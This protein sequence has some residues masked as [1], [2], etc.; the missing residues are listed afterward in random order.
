M[1][2]S[3][4]TQA[5]RELA[6]NVDLVPRVGNVTLCIE[7]DRE[8]FG[9]GDGVIVNA[10]P[11]QTVAP[12]H[13]RPHERPPTRSSRPVVCCYTAEPPADS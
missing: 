11:V 9:L 8:T 1:V 10:G 7:T 6:G 4:V 2:S 3:A 13:S 5:D 12:Q